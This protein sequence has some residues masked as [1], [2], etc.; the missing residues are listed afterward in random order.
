MS[1]IQGKIMRYH[2]DSSCPHDSGHQCGLLRETLVPPAFRGLPRFMA[3]RAGFKRTWAM[4]KSFWDALSF[5]ISVSAS[6]ITMPEFISGVVPAW[7]RSFVI[8]NVQ[9]LMHK[10][11]SRYALSN[12]HSVSCNSKCGL[13]DAW[14]LW[15]VRFL[16]FSWSG[17]MITF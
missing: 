17:S 14:H 2:D 8:Y 11:K 5:P 4:P 15:E 3:S 9:S 10:A 16:I 6:P 12:W 7:N 13:S 1:K